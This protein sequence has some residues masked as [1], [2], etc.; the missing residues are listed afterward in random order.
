MDT[1]TGACLTDSARSIGYMLGSG[2][3]G[4]KASRA[5]NHLDPVKVICRNLSHGISRT[6]YR[7]DTFRHTACLRRSCSKGCQLASTG[8][9]STVEGYTVAT[10]F[11]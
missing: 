9:N 5:C 3:F 10:V 8:V 11:A 4:C 6:N 1:K 7:E 2:P